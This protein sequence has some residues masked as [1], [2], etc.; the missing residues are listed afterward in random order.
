M[1]IRDRKKTIENDGY[2]AVQIGFGALSDKRATKAIKGHFAKADVALKKTLK[3]LRLDDIATLNVGDIIKADTLDVYKRQRR[4]R[5][6]L[7]RGGRHRRR[8]AGAE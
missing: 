7:H 6:P 5:N 3:E 1:C 4:R 2:E 8:A